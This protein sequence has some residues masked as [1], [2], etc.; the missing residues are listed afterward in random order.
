MLAPVLPVRTLYCSNT[1]A[2]QK[3]N[4]AR[5]MTQD[6][7]LP[8]YIKSATGLGFLGPVWYFSELVYFRC[9]LSQGPEPGLAIEHS[10]HRPPPPSDIQIRST[11]ILSLSPFR[12]TPYFLVPKHMDNDFY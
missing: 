2:N 6:T 8:Y 11:F 1:S 7:H 5:Y 4:K 3:K 12:P 9:A 10:R